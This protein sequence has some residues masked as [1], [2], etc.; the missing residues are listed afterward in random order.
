MYE[1]D[2]LEF[3]HLCPEAAAIRGEVFQREQGF[4]NEFDETDARAAHA[5]L[6]VNGEPA[7]ISKKKTAGISGGSPC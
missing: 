3:N 6:Y 1:T 4:V 2:I 5:V 7:A